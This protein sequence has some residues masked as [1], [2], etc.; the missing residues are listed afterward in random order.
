MLKSTIEEKT[1]EIEEGKRREEGLTSEV[2]MY[3]K[4]YED[5][6]DRNE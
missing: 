4:S 5:I 6:S 1:Q 2:D 3:L